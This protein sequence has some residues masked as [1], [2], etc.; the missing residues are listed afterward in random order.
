MEGSEF[1][2]AFESAISGFLNFGGN[3]GAEAFEHVNDQPTAFFLFLGAKR[4]RGFELGGLAR[5]I[6]TAKYTFCSLLTRAKACLKFWR[7]YV[8]KESRDT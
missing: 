8:E 2:S 1:E 7:A 5:H 3:L 4:T 6:I